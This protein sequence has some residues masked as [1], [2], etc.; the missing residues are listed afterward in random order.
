MLKT[1]SSIFVAVIAIFSCYT[2]YSLWEA[3]VNALYVLL[4]G[5][6]ATGIFLWYMDKS[7]TAN[8]N[9]NVKEGVLILLCTLA[10]Q[11]VATAVIFKSIVGV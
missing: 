9:V 4:A 2:L 7:T 5:A 8:F 1:V 6:F 3:N 10:I 11:A